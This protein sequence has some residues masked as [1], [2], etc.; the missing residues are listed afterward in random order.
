MQGLVSHGK[1]SLFYPKYNEKALK[2]VRVKVLLVL[3]L[4]NLWQTLRKT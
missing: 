1:L 3:V 2:V 4:P